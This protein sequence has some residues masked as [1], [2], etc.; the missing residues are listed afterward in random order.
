MI[1]IESY[2]KKQLQKLVENP[3]FEEFAF[4]PITQQRAIS[5]SLNPDADDDDI[6]LTIAFD[7]DKIAGYLGTL[8]DVFRKDENL[9]FA[10]LST[11]YVDGK[12]RGKRISQQLIANA[13]ESYNGNI[14]MTE[15]TQEAENLYK[16]IGK[17]QYINPKNG[18]RFYFKSELRTILPAKIKKT[19]RIK[20]LLSF[21]D[22][23]A[24]SILNIKNLG[25]NKPAFK[26]EIDEKIQ[27]DSI[28]FIKNFNN[29]RSVES[30]I[31]ALENPWVKEDSSVNEK[32]FFSSAAKEFKYFLVKIFNENN[33]I[34]CV[35]VLHLR[36]G[37]LK[38]PYIFSKTKM[39][40]LV[41]VLSYFVVKY[42]ITML[43]SYHS[44]LNSKIETYS[45]FPKIYTRDL[46]RR[47]FVHQ[48]LA[49]KSP[50]IKH[51]HFQDGDGDCLFT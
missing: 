28:L 21:T 11:I 9:K 32:Y 34:E 30:L 25:I 31:W 19:E 24:N 14:A 43:T 45:K 38:I 1:R 29:H 18:K 17:F 2:N 47:Y 49:T 40:Q 16:K 15:F 35:M 20:P 22:Y 10:W 12:Y 50:D 7:D 13:I 23:A 5:Q 46:E 36:D 6:L 48:E 3:H 27:N 44:E 4:L 33:D 8:P 41:E 39:D 51:N 26:F 37:H 42:N